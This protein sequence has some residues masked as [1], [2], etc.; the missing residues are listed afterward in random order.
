[1]ETALLLYKPYTSEQ[2][3]SRVNIALSRKAGGGPEVEG[4]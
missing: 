4:A 2:L 3:A 1:M